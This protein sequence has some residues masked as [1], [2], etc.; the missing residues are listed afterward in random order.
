M[1]RRNFFAFLP[2]APVAL[3]AE[4][5]KAD[6]SKDQPR[7]GEFMIS[8]Q[9]SKANKTSSTSIFSGLP[10]TDPTKQVSMAVGQDGNLWLKSL[11]GEWKKVVTE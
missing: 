2:V 3:I 10:V 4:G 11:G 9:G 6:V 7:N 8:L 5:A 1:N